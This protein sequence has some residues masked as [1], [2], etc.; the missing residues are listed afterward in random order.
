MSKTARTQSISEI[1]VVW[2][3]DSANMLAYADILDRNNVC[4]H[5]ITA[6]ILTLHSQHMNLYLKRF[7]SFKIRSLAIHQPVKILLNPCQIIGAT[8]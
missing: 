7:V 1:W 6:V 8:S 3:G 4:H 2:M 5:A